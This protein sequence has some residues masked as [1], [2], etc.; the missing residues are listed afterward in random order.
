MYIAAQSSE[1][2]SIQYDKLL[3]SDQESPRTPPRRERGTPL[4]ILPIVE[5]SKDAEDPAEPESEAP[6]HVPESPTIQKLDVVIGSSERRTRANLDLE[7]Q[8]LNG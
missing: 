2:Q 1:L 5:F 3:T 8:G 7:E 6:D 4:L